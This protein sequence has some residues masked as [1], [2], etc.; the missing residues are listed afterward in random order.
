S[1]STR[2]TRRT[3]SSPPPPKSRKPTPRRVPDPL[4][5][6]GLRPH[7][8]D[9]RSRSAALSAREARVKRSLLLFVAAFG[10][11]IAAL[12]AS[13]GC[14]LQAEGERCSTLNGNDDCQTGLV[15]TPKSKLGGNADICCPP[16]GSILASCTPSVGG[17]GGGGGAATTTTTA[18]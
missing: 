2:S 5:A 6:V 16:T 1:S 12:D 8:P 17:T 13:A 9:A 14:S 7:A 4:L 15:C 3:R 11:A 10:L 18:T